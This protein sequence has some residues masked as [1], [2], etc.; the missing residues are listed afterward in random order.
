MWQK[1]NPAEQAKLLGTAMMSASLVVMASAIGY[2][3]HAVYV[4]QQ[5]VPELLTQVEQTTEKIDPVLRQVDAIQ[6]QIPPILKE[7]EATR[8]LIPPILAEVA[9]VRREV[10]PILAEVA[11]TRTALP[12]LLDTTAKSVHEASTA[13]RALEP[14]IPVVVAEVRQTR[15]ALP[16][17]LDRA[18][19]LVASASTA[20]HEASKGAVSGFLGGIV[21]APF[22][23]IGGAGRDLTSAMGLEGDAGL[24]AKDDELASAA[25][26]AVIRAGEIGG[27]RSWENPDSK[28]RGTVRLLSQETRTEQACFRLRQT[29]TL[30]SGK[31]HHAEVEFCRQKDG[32]WA[33]SAK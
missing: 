6:A 24:T 9:A 20:G 4:V 16:G 19:R 7:V 23:L 31:T 15:E 28:N 21:T 10:S 8:A 33:Q 2:F 5:R 3:A 1:L 30:A 32:T 27:E 22:K 11:A 25:T 17:L 26:D 12:P 18:E 29:V 14:H 13:V